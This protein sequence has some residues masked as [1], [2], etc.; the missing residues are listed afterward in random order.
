MVEDVLEQ[1]VDDWLRRQGYFTRTN[2]RFGPRLGDAGYVARDHNQQSDLDVVAIRPAAPEGPD[3]VLAISCKAMQVGFSPN[4][5]LAA[6]EADKIY[7]GKNARKHLRELWDPIWMTSLR[8]AVRELTG[9]DEFTYVLAI[10]RL[11]TGG[12]DDTSIWRNHPVVGAN[13]GTTPAKVLT[14]GEMWSDLVDDVTERIEPSHVGR[15]AQLLK[16]I[17]KDTPKARGSMAEG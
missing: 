10:T 1:V 11:G 7:N 15:L 16:A 3:R 5:W 12:S 2:V 13:L 4:R 8:S 9:T 14:F 6:A 17:E